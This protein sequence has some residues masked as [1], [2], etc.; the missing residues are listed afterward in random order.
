MPR[1]SSNHFVRSWTISGSANIA[2]RVRTHH[3]F[4]SVAT[5]AWFHG[6]WCRVVCDLTREDTY[7]ERQQSQVRRSRPM[8]SFRVAK[9]FTNAAR[10]KSRRFDDQTRCPR[11]CLPP[12]PTAIDPTDACFR[13]PSLS[14]VFPD[15]LLK[16]ITNHRSIR[17]WEA[18]KEKPEGAR[19]PD[20]RALAGDATWRRQKGVASD[21]KR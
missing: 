3:A 9:L 12:C 6:S 8:A 20:R 13:Q 11:R 18:L 16:C 21:R 5:E 19:K 17:L 1:S 10:P 4:P 2:N 15:Y 7:H 14:H